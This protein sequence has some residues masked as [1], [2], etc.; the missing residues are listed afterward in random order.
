MYYQKKRTPIMAVSL[1]TPPIPPTPSTAPATS[2]SSPPTPRV[3]P[4]ITDLIKQVVPSIIHKELTASTSL[5]SPLAQCVVSYY[6]VPEKAAL[7]PT[8]RIIA[9]FDTTITALSCAEFDYMNETIL[10]QIISR[11]SELRDISL[12]CCP[13][14]KTLR[15]LLEATHLKIARLQNNPKIPKEEIQ[16]LKNKKVFIIS[17]I[18]VP[19][20]K[21]A[22]K[23]IIHLMHFTEKNFDEEYANR[24]LNKQPDLNVL[25]MMPAKTIL[26]FLFREKDTLPHEALENFQRLAYLLRSRGARTMEELE[27]GSDLREVTERIHNMSV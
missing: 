21:D 8:E 6:G 24:I 10:S 12:E 3:V 4:H 18:H 23:E 13:S 17:D 7:I 2:S 1:S 5:I 9:L 27:F 16:L 19:T 20:D 11:C 25:E 26:D 14:F 22:C 15:P